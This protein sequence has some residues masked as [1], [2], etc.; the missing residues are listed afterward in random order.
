MLQKQSLQQIIL[1]PRHYKIHQSLRQQVGPQ[2]SQGVNQPLKS[3][4]EGGCAILWD[5][6]FL[7]NGGFSWWFT[8]NPMV[9]SVKKIKLKNKHQQTDFSVKTRRPKCFT[10]PQMFTNGSFFWFIVVFPLPKTTT[11]HFKNVPF[12][13]WRAV[14][15]CEIVNATGKIGCGPQ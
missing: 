11:H 13:N 8:M 7:P 12:W 10:N 1:S 4:K 2:K 3:K 9:E 14:W 6:Q 5:S 15:S